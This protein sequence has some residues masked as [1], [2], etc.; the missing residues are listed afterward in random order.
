ML[1]LPSQ[2]L[3]LSLAA[4]STRCN[5]TCA[6][7]GLVSTGQGSEQ[8]RDSVQK[9]ETPEE[10]PACLLWMV[11]QS[12]RISGLLGTKQLF[13]FAFYVPELLV[14]QGVLLVSQ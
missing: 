12:V 9:A 3:L 8:H 1:G 6:G 4:P 11:P 7:I 10:L 5:I 2:G 14:T 13:W